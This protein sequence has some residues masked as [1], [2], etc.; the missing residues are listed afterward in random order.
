[1]RNGAGLSTTASSPA[2][3]IDR[4]A[5]TTGISGTSNSWVNGAVNVTADPEPTTCRVSPRR[6][7]ASTAAPRRAADLLAVERGRP[8][9]VVLQHRQ[10]RQRRG[11]Q[12]VRVKIDKTA[13][14]ISK[15]F[16]PS[17]YTDGAWTNQNVTV[18]FT[19]ADQGGSGLASCTAPVTTSTEGE[20]Q[21][22]VVPAR[23]T[24]ATRPPAPR[25]SASTRPL[26][27]HRL[28]RPRRE[29][30][31]LVQRRRHGELRASDALSG[32]ATKSADKVLGQ[33]ANQSATGS[34]TD[35]AG[36]SPATV[37]AASTST[38]PPPP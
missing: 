17:S 10:R 9:G 22:V 15:A 5:P 3:K 19:C 16:T 33:G 24:P 23:T 26:R 6:P 27:G 13:P 18:T 32:V 1:V 30:R 2:V 38:R 34:A 28:G 4:T 14:T 12:T 25:W 37:S 20:G 21:Q 8:H 7:T 31:R 11:A 29:Q 36:N 35:K